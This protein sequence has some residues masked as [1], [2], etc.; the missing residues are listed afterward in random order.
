MASFSFE[1]IYP[2]DSYFHVL[3]DD[4]ILDEKC[5][6]IANN[7]VDISEKLLKEKD[8]CKYLVSEINSLMDTYEEANSYRSK[9]PQKITLMY[10]NDCKEEVIR[11]F[12]RDENNEFENGSEYSMESC[13]SLASNVSA[14][15]NLVRQSSSCIGTEDLSGPTQTINRILKNIKTSSRNL[16]KFS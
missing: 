11:L 12:E 2:S 16:G 13:T 14:R 9:E 6:Y 3:E 5:S 10:A 15:S 4:K 1:K 7:I 8:R